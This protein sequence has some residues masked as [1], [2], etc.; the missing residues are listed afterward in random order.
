M[1]IG[2]FET[3]QNL[4]L[5][6]PRHRRCRHRKAPRPVESK[7]RRPSG[8]AIFNR[9]KFTD[10]TVF[11]SNAEAVAAL[12]VQTF[13]FDSPVLDISGRAALFPSMTTLGRFRVQ[14]SANAK[15]EIVKNLYWSLSVYDNFDSQPP[16][17]T[18]RRN[19]FGI[20]SSLGWTF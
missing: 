8:G 14:T 7:H 20:N 3:S 6:F 10:Q 12:D 4:D 18:D 13:Q 19:D 11:V 16:S 2:Q 15:I 5:Y 1:G 17:E 9:E